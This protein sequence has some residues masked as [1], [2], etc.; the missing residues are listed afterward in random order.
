M[1]L[2]MLDYFNKNIY[3]EE[4]SLLEETEFKNNKNIVIK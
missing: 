3:L 1:K 2:N 4:K